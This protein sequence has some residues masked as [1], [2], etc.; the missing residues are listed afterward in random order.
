MGEGLAEAL[1]TAPLLALGLAFLGGL[2]TSFTPC[3]YPI[4]PIT[5]TFIGA[6][7]RQQS[8]YFILREDI[9]HNRIPPYNERVIIIR[10]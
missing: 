5:V 9:W 7:R 6:C 1:Q 3:V 2:A 4:I 8:I 10:K